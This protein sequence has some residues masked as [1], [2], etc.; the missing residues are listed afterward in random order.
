VLIIS[1]NCGS[2]KSEGANAGDED[3]HADFSV[4]ACRSE[5]SRVGRIP[6]DR[7]HASWKVSRERLHKCCGFLMPNIDLRIC[8]NP[9]A[10]VI[11]CE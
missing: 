3:L 1:I 11:S 8:G 9:L 6:S 7:I 10:Q 5:H 4:I 2:A